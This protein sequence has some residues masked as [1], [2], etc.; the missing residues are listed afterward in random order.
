MSNYHNSEIPN[1]DHDDLELDGSL[2]Y[3]ADRAR[4]IE[5]LLIDKGICTAQEIQLQI[6]ER[7]SRSP[8]DGAKVVAH[9]WIDSEF[10]N[11]LLKEADVA[12]SQLGYELPDTTP[13][14]AVVENTSDVHYMVVCTLCS[15][16]PR[17]ML[18]RPPDWDKSLEYRSRAV[19]D[20]RGVMREIGLNLPSTTEVRVVDS[21][22][23]LR[24][25][26]LPRR[27]A[28]SENLSELELARLVTR[29]SMIGVTEALSPEI[30]SIA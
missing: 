6:D 18:G 19:V 20:P 9:A 23:D 29:D 30:L 11:L 25:L 2:G 13:Q 4:A 5:R 28:G 17:M 21:T 3:F 12:L 26:V 27:P 22:A 8:A 14:L 7:E 16:Y 1:D 10:K 15:C 24:Y